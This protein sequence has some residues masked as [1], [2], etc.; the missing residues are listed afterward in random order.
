MIIKHPFQVVFN[1]NCKQ[2]LIGSLI[3]LLV[4]TLCGSGCKSE[5]LSE[6]SEAG[7]YKKEVLRIGA[8]SVHLHKQTGDYGNEWY[9]FTRQTKWWTNAARMSAMNIENEELLKS[10]QNLQRELESLSF[11][12][13]DP[14]VT[15]HQYSSITLTKQ[16]SEYHVILREFYDTANEI[17]AVVKPYDD[18]GD[19]LSALIR[20][21]IEGASGNFDNATRTI[22]L[23]IKSESDL[24]KFETLFNRLF[25]CVDRIIKNKPKL[26]DAFKEYRKTSTQLNKY[27]TGLEVGDS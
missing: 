25:N 21:A 26:L 17:A 14:I 5:A 8:R 12:G 15:K 16:M 22:K 24:T 13:L 27:L 11:K 3:A 20:D 18:L 9:D 2:F 4:A 19:P 7:R 1:A 10:Y 6:K 23:A